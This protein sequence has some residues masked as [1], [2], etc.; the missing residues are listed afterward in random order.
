[1]VLALVFGEDDVQS[2]TWSGLGAVGATRL[3]DIPY[4]P[5]YDI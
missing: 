3:T 5:A 2:T 4:R 1:M